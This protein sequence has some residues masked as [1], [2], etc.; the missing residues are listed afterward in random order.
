VKV[1]KEERK[2]LKSGNVLRQGGGPPSAQVIYAFIETQK[3]NHR[4]SRMCRVLKVSKSGFYSWRGREPSARTRA[5][6]V[7]LEKITRIHTDN[8]ERETYGAPRIHFELRMLGVRCGRKRVARLMRETGLFGC[9]GR[10][11]KALT[12]V[13]SHTERTPSAPELVK[14]NFTPEAPDRLWVADIT[15]VCSWEGWLYLSFVLD[16]YSRKIVGWSMA[17]NLK[18]DLVLDALNARR[19]TLAGHIRD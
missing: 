18:T 3:A 13:R 7:L 16:T 11:R 12:T 9:G 4:I 10:S 2:I 6:A 15:Y 8:R 17:N 14:R 5:D 19:S 1:L